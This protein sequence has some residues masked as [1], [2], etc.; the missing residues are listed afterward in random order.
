MQKVCFYMGKTNTSESKENV[1]DCAL[2]LSQSP[3]Y[4]IDSLR[5]ESTSFLY[6]KKLDE[7]LG[8]SNFKSTEEC[9]QHLVKCI[10]QAVK[11]IR[12]E[13]FEK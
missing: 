8:E 7:K 4:N 12:R 1:T 2:E 13:K 11:E 6:K 10:H 5:D 3:L 9:N